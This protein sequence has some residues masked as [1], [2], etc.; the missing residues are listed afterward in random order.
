ML[1][2]PCGLYNLDSTDDHM[3]GFCAIHER[4]GKEIPQDLAQKLLVCPHSQPVRNVQGET[5]HLFLARVK[6]LK[7]I[8]HERS[9]GNLLAL[10]RYHL[11]R[12]CQRI[13][14]AIDKLEEFSAAANRRFEK[15]CLRSC[16]Q[17]SLLHP[18]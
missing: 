2:F 4:I 3:S 7:H 14:H 11:F 9:D 17:A 18:Q 15:L 12:D 6:M 8:T 10:D 16:V 1:N 13:E 5:I